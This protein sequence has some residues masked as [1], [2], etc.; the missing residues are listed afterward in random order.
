MH[1]CDNSARVL[2]F[3]GD[4]FRSDNYILR[5]EVAIMINAVPTDSVLRRHYEASHGKL[6]GNKEPSQSGGGVL[7]WL[8][9]IFGG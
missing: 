4:S 2:S 9:R 3:V 8:K 6:S 1:R 7:G 5:G